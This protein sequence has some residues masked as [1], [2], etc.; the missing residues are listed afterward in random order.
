MLNGG[1][2][3][4]VGGGLCRY[5]TDA[6][7]LVPH[8]EKMLYDNAMLIRLA[9]WAFAETGDQLFRD[10]IE[11][12]IGWLLR[13]MRVDGGG[14]AASLDADS[15]GEEGS[16]YTWDQVEIE[17]VLGKRRA[18]LSLCLHAG[19]AAWLGRQADHP[20]RTPMQLPNPAAISAAAGK[21][22]RRARKA[23]ASRPRRQ[24]AGRLERPGDRRDWPRPRAA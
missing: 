24:G 2:Y 20:Q 9:N 16:Y 22:L 8:F 12:T 4:H 13:E 19:S 23:R 11:T 5:S 21:A 10:R 17:A 6:E 7:W 14:F 3:D 18:G 1:I 15:D